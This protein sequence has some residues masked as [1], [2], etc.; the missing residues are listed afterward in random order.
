MDAHL[1]ALA[2]GVD[3]TQ[4]GYS[5]VGSGAVVIAAAMDRAEAEARE[6]EAALNA[7]LGRPGTVPAVGGRIGGDPAWVR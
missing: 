2:L 4:I 5:Y 7:A 3:R 1:D 6:A